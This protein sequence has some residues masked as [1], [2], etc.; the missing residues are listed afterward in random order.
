MATKRTSKKAATAKGPKAA[1]PDF[2]AL[3]RIG[4]EMESLQLRGQWTKQN[5]D[6]LLAEAKRA[7]HG[8]EEYLEFLMVD[9]EP[10]WL[11]GL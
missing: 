1:E 3:E 11:K 2:E 6:R 5:F 10:E 9:A 4:A 8:D 7:A